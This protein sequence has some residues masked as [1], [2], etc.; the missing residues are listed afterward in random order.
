MGKQATMTPPTTSSNEK[1]TTPSSSKRSRSTWEERRE[2]EEGLVKNTAVDTVPTREGREG[3]NGKRNHTAAFHQ[4]TWTREE[5]GLEKGIVASSTSPAS[6][7]TPHDVSCSVA[8]TPRTPASIKAKRDTQRKEVEEKEEED[9]EE[10]EEEEEEQQWGRAGSVSLTSSTASS[11]HESE[12]EVDDNDDDGGADEGT[13]EKG[14]TDPQ[15]VSPARRREL[16]FLPDNA[17]FMFDFTAG[18]S[19]STME[20]GEEEDSEGEEEKGM[21]NEN[22][23]AHGE[24]TTTTSSPSLPSS[25][26]IKEPRTRMD[27]PLEMA[28]L[29]LAIHV[30]SEEEVHAYRER[31]LTHALSTY[32]TLPTVV[33]PSVMRTRLARGGREAASPSLCFTPHPLSSST[34]SPP[35]HLSANAQKKWWRK[36]KR[37]QQEAQ[38]QAPVPIPLKEAIPCFQKSFLKYEEHLWRERR[39][40][41]GMTRGR[42]RGSERGRGGARGV[43]ERS[44]GPPW[45]KE[46]REEEKK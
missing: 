40:Q 22:E 17:A 33:D 39:Q 46:T 5:T 31:G 26:S 19:T 9:E 37:L 11:V 36:W 12:N 34:V 35:S 4:K 32:L 27:A 24:L 38:A 44:T 21:E 6:S 8:S 15:A 45:D 10:V 1:E 41:N 2:T 43:V 42:G 13:S 7:K 28:S 30:F 29:P 20:H 3:R 14:S 25:S 16:L 23:E 18:N